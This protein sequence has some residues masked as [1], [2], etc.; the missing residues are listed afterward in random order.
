MKGLE[1]ILTQGIGEM[2]EESGISAVLRREP[3]H[4]A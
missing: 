4:P 3:G 2:Q 1:G